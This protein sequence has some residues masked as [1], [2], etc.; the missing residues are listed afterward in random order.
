MTLNLY[1]Q[2]SLPLSSRL[3]YQLLSETCSWGSKILN[4]QNNTL[5]TELFGVSQ[6]KSCL[7]AKILRILYF[8]LLFILKCN[9]ST[10]PGSVQKYVSKFVCFFLSL[11][12][13]HHLD[14]SKLLREG[15][16]FSMSFS[17]SFYSVF[18]SVGI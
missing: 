7:Q 16:N 9:P 6:S 13:C 11:H 2:P 5:K 1:L 12:L 8:S 17:L 4:I 10:N 18:L 15:Q 14:A 3:T